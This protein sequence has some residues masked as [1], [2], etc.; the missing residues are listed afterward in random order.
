MINLEVEFPDGTDPSSADYPHGEPRD[1]SAPGAGDGFPYES[2]VAK[3]VYGFFEAVLDSQTPAVVPT[4][5]PETAIASQVLDTLRLILL[6]RSELAE[7]GGNILTTANRLVVAPPS[8]LTVV[9]DS[10]TAMTTAPGA[11]R[12]ATDTLDL[13]LAVATQKTDATWAVGDAAG[14]IPAALSPVG[15][16]WF[17]RFIVAKPD[18]STDLAWDTSPVAANFFLDANAIAAG[19]SDAT[20]YRRYGWTYWAAGAI[21]N[22]RQSLSD[23]SR[24]VWDVPESVHDANVAKPSTTIL[25]FGTAAPPGAIAMATVSLL[26][27]DIGQCLITEIA[28]AATVPT[29]ALHTVRTHNS[30]VQAS[31]HSNSAAGEWEMDSSSQ[32]RA[33]VAGSGAPADLDL[34]V[35]CPGWRDHGI[36]A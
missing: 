20:L 3:D 2:P 5:N 26:D 31:D 8:G 21:K 24:Y 17:R 1:V 19:F 34:T 32:L 9:R 25:N 23:P 14:G 7:N 13:I 30:V 33:G 11:V 18:G 27:E 28:Q 16:G 6:Q 4:G 10:G 36:A 12:G 35:I 15:T 22:H 29:L